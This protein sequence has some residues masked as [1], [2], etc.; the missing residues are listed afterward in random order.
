MGPVPRMCRCQSDHVPRGVSLLSP[1]PLKRTNQLTFCLS[2]FR[3]IPVNVIKLLADK[4]AH[5][6][7]HDRKLTTGNV[8]FNRF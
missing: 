2:V 1:P 8:V 3:A 7:W 6:N 5:R 4:N